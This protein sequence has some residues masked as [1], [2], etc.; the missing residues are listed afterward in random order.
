MDRKSTTLK[1]HSSQNNH[2]T[3]DHNNNTPPPIRRERAD[4]LSRP[5]LP[6][7]HTSAEK[8]KPQPRE[9]FPTLLQFPAILCQKTLRLAGRGLCEGQSHGRAQRASRFM[10]KLVPDSPG[11]FCYRFCHLCPCHSTHKPICRLRGSEAVQFNMPPL[12]TDTKLGKPREKAQ[13]LSCR[14]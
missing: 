7:H 2:H 5:Q 4:P 1:H 8:R 3:D 10:R 9:R 13:I 11:N 6:T 12:Q 14:P